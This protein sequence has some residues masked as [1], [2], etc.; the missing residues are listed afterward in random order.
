MAANSDRLMLEALLRNQKV[1][2]SK[3]APRLCTARCVGF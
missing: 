1:D 2:K 3:N